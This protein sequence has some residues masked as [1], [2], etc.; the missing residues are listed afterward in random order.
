MNGDLFWAVLLFISGCVIISLCRHIRKLQEIINTSAMDE[1]LDRWDEEYREIVS[2][3]GSGEAF[4]EAHTQDYNIFRSNVLIFVSRVKDLNS[5]L[6]RS[7]SYLEKEFNTN[8]DV[9]TLAIKLS[10]VKGAATSAINRL[11]DDTVDFLKNEEAAHLGKE[12]IDEVLESL[13]K[14]V[15]NNNFYDEKKD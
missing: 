11:V 13:S 3:Y 10:A 6:D 1:L 7:L 2:H 4:E 14:E 15:K 8:K 9:K 5:G 12:Y